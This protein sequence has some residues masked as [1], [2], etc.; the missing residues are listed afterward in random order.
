MI[1]PEKESRAGSGSGAM[2]DGGSTVGAPEGTHG[3]LG[4]ALGYSIQSCR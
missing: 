3:T 4:A 2:S 1:G